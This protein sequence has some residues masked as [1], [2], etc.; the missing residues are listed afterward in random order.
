MTSS[1]DTLAQP[2]N[3]SGPEPPSAVCCDPAEIQAR[4]V[5]RARSK[6][7][8]LP[9]VVALAE[10]GTELEQSYRNSI[11]CASLYVQEAGSLSSH[12]CGNR[13]CV[14]CNRIR[15]GKYINQYKP[16]IDGWDKP[17]FVTL[18]IKACTAERL[19][20][21]IDA[22]MD[23]D[24]RCRDSLRKHRTAPLKVVGL[25]K[26]ECNANPGA[27]TYNP[28]FHYIVESRE[29]AERMREAWL[30]QF[31]N[32]TRGAAQDV[33]PC[34]DGSIVELLKY[35]TKLTVK[36]KDGR[37]AVPPAMLDTIFRALRGRRTIQPIGF[38]V[39]K[40]ESEEGP[41]ELDASIPALSRRD[42]AVLWH[43]VQEMADW[44]DLRTGEV[45]SGYVPS[46][47]ERDMAES[48]DRLKRDRA[49]QSNSESRGVP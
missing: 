32:R 36:Q 45:L 31:P 49:L 5:R 42:E 44:V 18:T 46:E 1:L 26:L 48:V 17:Y 28:H 22:M 43:W 9:F 10:L 20:A 6:Y 15:M 40:Q 38:R 41:L 30:K 34:N 23:A 12:Y 16:V 19:P 7:I 13:W 39:P 4:H 47:D 24:R 14:V 29:M 2:R 35:A 37:Y 8:G 21:T 11:Y 33:I 27:G 3:T 25:R